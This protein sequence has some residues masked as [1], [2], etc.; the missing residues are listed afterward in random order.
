MMQVATWASVAILGPGAVAIFV[1]FLFDAKKI[2][3]TRDTP[4]FEDEG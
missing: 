2:F 4:P 3:A 1:W